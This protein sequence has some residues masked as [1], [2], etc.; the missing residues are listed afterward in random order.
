MVANQLSNCRDHLPKMVKISPASP[1]TTHTNF[2]DSFCL[3][4]GAVVL[5]PVL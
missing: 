1:I 4:V 3:D 5:V 2:A